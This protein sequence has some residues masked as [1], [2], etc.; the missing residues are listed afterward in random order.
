[1]SEKTTDASNN[2]KVEENATAGQPAAENPAAEAAAP[3]DAASRLAALEAELA[4]EREQKEKFREEVIRRAADFENFRKQ[5]ERETSMASSRMEESIIKSLLPVL[6]DVNRVL[7]NAP[8]ADAVGEEVKPYVEGVLLFKKNL[9]RWLEDRGVKAIDAIG[10]RLDVNYHE[11][12]SQI[13]QPDCEP[14]TVIEEY[15]TGYLLGE[16]VIRHAKVIVSR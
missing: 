1:M 2:L 13:E 4:T 14:E 12:I 5:K 3:Q 8:A 9:D 6:D 10:T 15:Q 16:K 7:C 11:A